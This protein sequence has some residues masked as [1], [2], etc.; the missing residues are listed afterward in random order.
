MMTE[1]TAEHSNS[2]AISPALLQARRASVVHSPSA[3]LLI[4]LVLFIISGPFLTRFRAGQIVASVF[5]TTVLVTATM[6]MGSRRWALIAAR[7]LLIPALA[8]RWLAH[9]RPDLLPEQIFPATAM[10]FVG[11]VFVSVLSAII[12][13]PEVTTET[14]CAG[15]CGY[16]LLGLFWA[17]AYSLLES[18]SP[19]AFAMTNRAPWPPLEMKGFTAIFFSYVTLTSVNSSDIIPA[20]P[21][22]QMLSMLEAITGNFYMAIMIARLVALHSSRR[23]TG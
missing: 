17:F 1:N 16:L 7:F 14:L 6:A 11:C 23:Q 21:V 2:D 20:A 22:A 9:V 18:C 13:A 3:R 5:F 12:T 8:A 10:L 15:L 19:N 4:A